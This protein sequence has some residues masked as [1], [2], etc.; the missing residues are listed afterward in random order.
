MLSFKPK[1]SWMTT[2]P[3]N[4]P[5]PSGLTKNDSIVPLPLARGTETL[6]E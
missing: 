4:G 3:G 1:A 6:E 2:S 5:N